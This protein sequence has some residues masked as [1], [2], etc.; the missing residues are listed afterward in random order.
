[1]VCGAG[2]II[3]VFHRRCVVTHPAFP[4]L[5]HRGSGS[6][7]VNEKGNRGTPWRALM[8]RVVGPTLAEVVQ[9]D[10]LVIQTEEL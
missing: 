8:K 1:M 4:A 5:Q 3:I 7:S 6:G 10:T 9:T 2:G